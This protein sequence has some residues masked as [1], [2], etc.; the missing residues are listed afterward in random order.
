MTLLA[1]DTCTERLIAGLRSSETA[2]DRWTNLDTREAGGAGNHSLDL[3]EAVRALLEGR[4]PDA[5]GVALGPGSFTGVRIGLA[6]AKGLAEGWGVPLVGLD[7]LAAMAHA[8]RTLVPVSEAAVLPVIDARKK[9]FYGALYSGANVLVPPSDRGPEAWVAEAARVWNGPVA[10][11]GYQGG[12]LAQALGEALPARWSVL[13]VHDWAPGLL[14]QLEAGWREGRSL[15][16]D[17]GPRYLRL[18]EAEEMLRSRN[19]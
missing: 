15:A 11:S 3:I 19:G 18:S 10:L 1:I 6:S 17:A 9:K 8:W 16:S 14:D 4:R 5:V 13:T 12:L 2:T 7:N